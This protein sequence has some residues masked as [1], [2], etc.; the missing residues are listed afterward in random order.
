MLDL[1]WERSLPLIQ[2]DE[3]VIRECFGEYSASIRIC[4]H[5]AITMGCRNSNYVIDTDQGRY[6]LRMA[7]AAELNNESAAYGAFHGK[8]PMPKLLYYTGKRNINLFIYEFVEGKP[9]QQLIVERNRCDAEFL[10][11]AARAAAAIHNAGLDDI[12][13]A[14]FFDTPPFHTWYSLFMDN[15]QA[16]ARMGEELHTRLKKL[17]AGAQGMLDEIDRRHSAIHSD[18]RPA[19]MIITNTGK[20]VVVDWEYLAFGHPLADIGQFFRYRQFFCEEDLF[21]FE[22]EYNRYANWRLPRDWAELSMLRDLVNPL[23]M[24]VAAEE[25]PAKN[26][27]LLKIILE[28]VRHFGY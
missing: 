25:Q 24:L 8:V 23:Q 4:R 2:A 12:V 15:L 20:L 28:T 6:L 17:V 26:A 1:G 22:D 11:Q 3:D 13:G 14:T 21:R 7:P 16:R 19:N 18:F 27:D 5:T 10:A 9:L